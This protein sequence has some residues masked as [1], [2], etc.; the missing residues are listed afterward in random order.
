MPHGLAP[1]T[2]I[3]IL[4][5][6]VVDDLVTEGI[7]VPSRNPAGEFAAGD[8]WQGLLMI[9]GAASSAITLVQAGHFGIQAIARRLHRWNEDQPPWGDDERER[10][11]VYIKAHREREVLNLKQQPSLEELQ[12]WLTKAYEAL[13]DRDHPVSC[14]RESSP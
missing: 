4:P 13:D 10:C 2:P 14:F 12:A 3:F 5:K 1:T 11:L 9:A 6:E 8:W 7:A